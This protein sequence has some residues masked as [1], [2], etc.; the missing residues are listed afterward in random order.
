MKIYYKEEV[1][2]G[3]TENYER[4]NNDNVGRSGTKWGNT[5]RVMTAVDNEVGGYGEWKKTND[6]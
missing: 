5:E 2:K 6:W 4:Q 1:R 3:I